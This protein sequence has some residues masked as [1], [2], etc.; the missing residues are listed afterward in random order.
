MTNLSA[1]CNLSASSRSRSWLLALL[2]SAALGVTGLVPVAQAADH[3]VSTKEM[4]LKL[5]DAQKAYQQ[6][7]YAEVIAKLK[8]AEG[9]AKKSPWDEHLINQ[10]AGPAYQGAK[11]NAEAEKRYEA[12]LTDGLTSEAEQQRYVRALAGIAFNQGNY[13]KALEWANKAIKGGYADDNVRTIVEESYRQKK[14]YKAVQ[15]IEEEAIAAQTKQG[16]TPK[17]HSLEVLLEACVKQGDKEC[18]TKTFERLVTY[19]SAANYWENLLY[20]L[21]KSDMSDAAKLQLYRLMLEVG[22]LKNASDY[23]EMA[24]I[25]LDEGSPGEAQDI[26]EKGFAN[27]VFADQRSQ[28]KNKRLLDTA[29]RAAADLTAQ[30]P[31]K[32]K[33][34]DASQTGDAYVKLGYAYLGFK[35]YDK[36]IDA[37]TKGL[38]KGGLANGEAEGRLLL[39]VAQYKAGHHDDA[40][41]TFHQVK[42]DPT[43]ER[44]GNLWA[45]RARQPDPAGKH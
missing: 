43:L 35:Q 37:L 22:V 27:K 34:A 31:A 24:A 41:K 36:A 17:Q 14:D 23:T 7:R 19:Y 39:G 11:D 15:K 32:T 45:L 38:A 10:L 25:A 26:L 30:L 21:A 42:G 33:E 29:K 1:G 18:Q 13:D 3:T 2:L 28:D 12:L 4:G 40:A 20:E 5:T 16:G 6:H 8:E 44:V 9:L